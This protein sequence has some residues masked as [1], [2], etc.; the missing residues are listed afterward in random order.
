MSSG[1]EK[2][3]GMIRLIL[4]VEDES[5]RRFA[6]S[7]TQS[8]VLIGRSAVADLRLSDPRVGLFHGRVVFDE[9]KA[10]FEDL[11]S[12]TGSSKKGQRLGVGQKTSILDDAPVV[13]GGYRLT[14]SWGESDE[15]HSG[16]NP[17]ASGPDKDSDEE[18]AALSPVAAV[19]RAQRLQ[20][21]GSAEGKGRI[22]FKEPASAPL[23]Q[24]K[25]LFM[26]A[27]PKLAPA[28]AATPASPPS[29]APA[30]P[31]AAAPTSGS[32][33]VPQ[34]IETKDRALTPPA[35]AIKLAPAWTPSPNRPPTG[36]FATRAL[37]PSGPV[38]AVPTAE[39]ATPPSGP[40]ASTPS[41]PGP[42]PRATPGWMAAVMGT[43]AK[44][45]AATPAV[46]SKP[47]GGDSLRKTKLGRRGLRDEDTRTPSGGVT[48]RPESSS[49]FDGAAVPVAV[50]VDTSPA[51]S[52]PTLLGA[53]A[54]QF[55]PKRPKAPTEDASRA[56]TEAK[57][58]DVAS[59][60]RV[61]RVS[62]SPR[63]PK[64]DS[65]REAKRQTRLLVSLF[66]ITLVT[67]F[68]VGAWL[69]QKP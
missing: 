53:P 59:V 1:Y 46:V 33:P 6:F 56:G 47:G 57:Q 54:L 31:S 29:P 50:P 30:S 45:V 38:A 65:A 18:I 5:G 12:P 26:A 44:G 64:V 66:V 60:P 9:M 10:T 21:R 2:R 39:A 11:V 48:S 16:P 22:A 68:S 61:Q 63:R 23:S 62:R 41:P 58:P 25:T 28:P 37:T 15:G 32:G 19:A 43:P 36:S 7:A 67:V 4:T 49:P 20:S 52:A 8:P 13:L 3:R 69:V 42:A 14:A 27:A 55:P 17:F 35:F 24:G 34:K 51:G 40:T